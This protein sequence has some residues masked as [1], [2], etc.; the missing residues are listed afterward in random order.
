MWEFGHVAVLA[1]SL[2]RGGEYA[3]PRAA[4]DA[5]AAR[6]LA[7]ASLRLKNCPRATFLSL[8]QAGMIRGIRAGRYTRAKENREHA[9]YA[10]ELLAERPSLSSSEPDHLWSM[11]IDGADTAHNDQMHVVLSL[12]N[13]GLIL[14][15]TGCAR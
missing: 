14:P 1:A 3:T 5:A 13:R 11:V 9:L 8:C 6:L 10:V 12:W 15:N 2:Y 4:W 7:T